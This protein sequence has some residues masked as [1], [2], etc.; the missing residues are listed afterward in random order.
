MEETKDT[1]SLTAH[2]ALYTD[3]VDQFGISS[4]IFFLQTSLRKLFFEQWDSALSAKPKYQTPRWPSA[5]YLDFS[6]LSL[7]REAPMTWY[8]Q[9]VPDNMNPVKATRAFMLFSQ[10]DMDNVAV[11]FLPNHGTLTLRITT[12]DA[13]LFKGTLVEGYIHC[14]RAPGQDNKY[15]F[16]MTDLVSLRGYNF[17]SCCSVPHA[18]LDDPVHHQFNGYVY[19]DVLNELHQ[20][21]GLLPHCSLE[22]RKTS[23]ITA[24]QLQVADTM[25]IADFCDYA[26]SRK[27][28]CND[29][30]TFIR[31]DRVLSLQ[32][33]MA[34]RLTW[35][36]HIEF[37][38]GVV[39]TEPQR[40]QA[41]CAT[42]P[43]KK[44]SRKKRK[45]P[46]Y[47]ADANDATHVA[48]KPC[49]ALERFSKYEAAITG[50]LGALYRGKSNSHVLRPLSLPT[51]WR[52]SRVCLDLDFSEVPHTQSPGAFHGHVVA[53]R[54]EI[55]NAD[56]THD[57]SY[58]R[59]HVTHDFG[60]ADVPLVSHGY[61]HQIIHVLLQDISW[62]I[63]R[64]QLGHAT[65]SK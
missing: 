35:M 59:C 65:N 3:L 2:R 26:A 42:E 32:G 37:H 62:D 49:D 64:K 53:V 13:N 54:P 25:S 1:P 48:V 63:L 34:R 18:V 7:I 61:L 44:K 19:G 6:G 10:I 4:D 28:A 17:V 41:S 15:T 45:A 8:A 60:Y 31:Y 5:R 11:V 50:G 24:L 47:I 23:D 29:A 46:E 22:H 14:R 12:K 9:R 57:E 56:D 51:T 20:L 27:E 52:E 43:T 36:P 30:W 16:F 40:P 58:V 38:V 33:T 39:A 21:I 55:C